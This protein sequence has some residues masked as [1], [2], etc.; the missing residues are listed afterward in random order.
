MSS[1][2]VVIGSNYGDEG[3]GLVVNSLTR[4][5]PSNTTAVVRFNGGAQ[6]GHTVQL[7][8]GHRHVFSHFGSGAL[9][10]AATI[11]SKHFIINPRV[12]HHESLELSRIRNDLHMDYPPVYVSGNCRVTMPTDVWVN[13]YIETIRGT[14]RHGSCGIGINETVTRY[15]TTEAPSLGQLR[16]WSPR[17]IMEY[18][19][20]LKNGYVLERLEQAGVIIDGD[21]IARLT[22]EILTTQYVNSLMA[23]M[24]DDDDIR[25][26]PDSKLY[27]DYP[28]LV[29]EGAQGLLLDEHTGEFPYVTRSSTGLT[30]VMDTAPLDRP[31]NVWYVTRAYLTRHGAGPLVGEDPSIG[32]QVTDLTNKPNDWQGSLR[33]APLDPHNVLANIVRDVS[34]CSRPV[35]I[36]I[37]VTCCD[38]V[39]PIT[40]E[41]INSAFR[42]SGVFNSVW[43]C[44]DPTGKTLKLV[45]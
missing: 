19:D 12:Y 9:S 37:V 14:D 45:G 39:D 6:A 17:H 36:N 40:V 33:F 13:R 1:V 30:N 27:T 15:D 29:F 5:F 34:A 35:V 32:S 25:I 41:L 42:S 8:S 28:H 4:L 18:I 7:E 23:F 22:H 24:W 21:I 31:L 43:N 26:M 38:Q 20:D 2:N 16:G 44:S 10:G 11:L 3:K